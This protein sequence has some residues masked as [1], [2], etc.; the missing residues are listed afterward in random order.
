MMSEG[1]WDFRPERRTALA[2]R[3][4]A[5]LRSDPRV[6]SVA[7]APGSPASPAEDGYP[8]DLLGH[9]HRGAGPRRQRP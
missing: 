1:T 3:V 8:A 7:L 2:E 6:G 5:A 9:R 4:M